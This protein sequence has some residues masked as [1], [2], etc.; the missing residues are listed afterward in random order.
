MRTTKAFTLIE[1]LVVISIIAILIAILLP[2]LSKAR[3]SSR[4]VSCQA[5][6]HQ[7]MI[8]TL[9]FAADNK[10]KLI[11]RGKTNYTHSCQRTVDTS[12]ESEEANPLTNFPINQWVEQYIGV[13]RAKILFC[14]GS[15]ST[16][17][18]RTPLSP[19][20]DYQ[21]MTYQYFGDINKKPRL[22]GTTWSASVPIPSPEDVHA[23]PRT[24]IWACMSLQVVSSGLYIGHDAPGTI[25]QYTGQ[26]TARLDGSAEWIP[27]DQLQMYGY[28]PSSLRFYWAG[29]N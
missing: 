7:L 4:R 22:T 28:V 24:P 25:K 27:A 21:Y 3:E 8:G 14:T 20:Y 15:L 10:Q 11:N 1:L 29:L 16:D 12:V 9:S 5:R 26:N 18:S 13:S 19:N 2:A 23:S 17:P 6:H